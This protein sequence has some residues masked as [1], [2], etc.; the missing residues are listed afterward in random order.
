MFQRGLSARISRVSKPS[1]SQ[2]S[3]PQTSMRRPPPAATKIAWFIR[4]FVDCPPVKQL[5]GEIAP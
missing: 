2:S 3:R 5:A 1:G 4:Q